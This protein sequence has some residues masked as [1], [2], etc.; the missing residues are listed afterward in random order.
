MGTM[1]SAVVSA[2]IA[3]VASAPATAAYF[4]Q[5][6]SIGSGVTVTVTDDG[7]TASVLFDEASVSDLQKYY[8]A[9]I[10]L[11]LVGQS[12]VRVDVRGFYE[13]FEGAAAKLSSNG[14]PV[15]FFEGDETGNWSRSFYLNRMHD[16]PRLSLTT[17]A[18]YGSTMLTVDSID[19]TV[20]DCGD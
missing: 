18:W 16:A 10:P 19:L 1:K 2:V 5:G 14:R 3:V 13:G 20:E 9:S 7:C 6:Y 8:D 12:A 4:E 17:D 15:T 11:Y